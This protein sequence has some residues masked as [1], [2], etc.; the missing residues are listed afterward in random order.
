MDTRRAIE[1]LG[2][3]RE[4][5]VTKSQTKKAKKVADRKSVV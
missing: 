5:Y 1:N 4:K 3:Q 2:L